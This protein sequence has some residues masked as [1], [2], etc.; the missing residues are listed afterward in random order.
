[1]AVAR[2]RSAIGT[3]GARVGGGVGRPDVGADGRPDVLPDV[4]T[5]VDSETSTDGP[6]SYTLVGGED[7]GDGSG[8]AGGSSKAMMSSSSSS[9]AGTG[10]PG[11]CEKVHPPTTKGILCI[12][13]R[14][15]KENAL[16]VVSN[17]YLSER[18]TMTRADK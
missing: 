2:I 12:R 10:K 3:G 1:M 15:M 18:H 6:I 13:S 7:G 11:S 14:V 4:D 5:D 8:D 9:T 16:L 17:F